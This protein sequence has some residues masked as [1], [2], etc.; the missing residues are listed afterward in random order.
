MQDDDQHW[1]WFIYLVFGAI[2]LV[3]VYNAFHDPI[4]PERPVQEAE[5]A[6]QGRPI[7][8]PYPF[9][10]PAEEEGMD[11]PWECQVQ[12]EDRV[13]RYLLYTNGKATQCEALPG[14]LD[15]GEDNRTTCVP[16]AASPVN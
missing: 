9:P 2:L 3:L 13:A 6:C 10:P 12:C 16:P 14:C 7:L 8:V 5:V 4:V 1:P 15:W 11:S